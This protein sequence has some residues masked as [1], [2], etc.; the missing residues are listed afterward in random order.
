[1]KLRHLLIGLIAGSITT[2]CAFFDDPVTNAEDLIPSRV[3]AADTASS[4]TSEA[5]APA[6]APQ[7]SESNSAASLPAPAAP[8][9]AQPEQAPAAVAEAPASPSYLIVAPIESFPRD[10]QNIAVVHLTDRSTR[11]ELALCKALMANMPAIEVQELPAKPLTV[12][13]WPVPNDNAG[14]NCIEMIADY[15]PIELTPEA[16]KRISSDAA[17]P[18]LLTRNLPTDKRMTYDTSFMSNSALSATVSQWI[19]LLGSSP[20]NWPPYRRAR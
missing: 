9:T 13:V 6:P 14:A 4:G 17:G 12:V 19:T 15:E 18:F 7:A 3:P 5:P 16:E 2:G 8:E 11:R 1:M 20:D 10:A